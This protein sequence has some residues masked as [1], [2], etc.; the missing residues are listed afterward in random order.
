[1]KQAEIWF[2]KKKVLIHEDLCTRLLYFDIVCWPETTGNSSCE[3]QLSLA[4]F[5]GDGVCPKSKGKNPLMKGFKY[6]LISYNL[7]FNWL[8]LFISQRNVDSVNWQSGIRTHV[9]A[10]RHPTGVSITCSSSLC[11]E[12]LKGN[13]PS[14]GDHRGRC[15][16]HI[17]TPTG[18]AYSMRYRKNIPQRSADH[19]LV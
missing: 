19:Q 15:L 13:G 12:N 10:A 9:T 6:Y 4:W 8:C 1:M 11:Q 7:L 3:K 17:G 18:L 14:Q 2:H 16:M 5:S